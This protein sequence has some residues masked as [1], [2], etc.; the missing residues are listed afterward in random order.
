MDDPNCAN[1]EKLA[2]RLVPIKQLAE[3]DRY[4][5]NISVIS[6]TWRPSIL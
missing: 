3:M 6:F 2:I 1:K 5:H 4:D